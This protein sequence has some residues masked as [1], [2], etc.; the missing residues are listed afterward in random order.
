[1]GDESDEEYEDRD[2]RDENL[3]AEPVQLRTDEEIPDTELATPREIRA[4]WAATMRNDRN[5]HKRRVSYA[6]RIKASELLAKSHG[7]FSD[8]LTVEGQGVFDISGLLREI[9]ASRAKNAQDE[10]VEEE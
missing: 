8:R 5:V 3:E 1:M 7:M 6:K 10:Q 2:E 4:F 9:H